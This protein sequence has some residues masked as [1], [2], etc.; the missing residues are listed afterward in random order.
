MKTAF[1]SGASGLLGNLV[2][3]HLQ[4][5]GYE[6]IGLE[7]KTKPATNKVIH[8]L[9]ELNNSR[10]DVLINLA[11][12]PIAGKPWTAA[13]KTTLL[14]SR[15]G[16]T[17][18][19]ADHIKRNNITVGHCITGSAIGY[20]GTGVAAVDES[21]PAG[22]D[23]SAH[24]CKAWEDAAAPLSESCERLSIIRTGLVLHPAQ[25]YLL[26]LKLTTLFGVGAVFGDGK[27]GQSWIDHRDWLAAVIFILNNQLSGIFN[28]TAPHPV[29]QQQLIDTLAKTLKRPRLMRIPKFALSPAGEL[30]TLFIDG[31]W[32]KPE[33]L[34]SN[35][36]HFNYPEL[37]QSLTDL[38]A[39]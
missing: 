38:F 36:F 10:L 26:P 16:F 12:A 11:G 23:F 29:S 28:L 32:V 31:Q 3:K 37:S 20:Y 17:N 30:K 22:D 18:A 33:A 7:H 1:I 9:N 13:R 2:N 27:Q 25:G 35:G 34:L 6:T 39:R 19:L 21:S 15:V 8:N 24:L 5:Q 4:Y 14:D